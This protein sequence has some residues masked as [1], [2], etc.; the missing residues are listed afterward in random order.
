M[1]WE[2]ECKGELTILLIN[3]A[4]LYS[5]LTLKGLSV[6]A[7]YKWLIEKCNLSLVEWHNEL[8]KAFNK[9]WK[10]DVSSKVLIFSWRVLHNYLATRDRSCVL[11]YT[12]GENCS[13]LFFLGRFS[14]KVW[15]C[16]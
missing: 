11:C 2:E 13:H 5:K 7:C 12:S 8:Q 9:M 10:N 15:G 14:F 4:L 6:K 16:F 1:A 3:V